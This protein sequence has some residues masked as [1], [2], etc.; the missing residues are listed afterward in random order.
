MIQLTRDPSVHVR[1]SAAWT[2]GRICELLSSYLTQ[3]QLH[4]L[5]VAI[6]PGLNETPRVASN[7]AWCF[8]NLAEQLAAEDHEQTTNALSGYFETIISALHTAGE[9]YL[10]LLF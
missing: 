9:M 2:L 6:L 10:I 1:D 5:I 8:I 3:E 4:S 7:C